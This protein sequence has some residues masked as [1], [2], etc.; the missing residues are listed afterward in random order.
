MVYRGL[1]LPVIHIAD[2]DSRVPVTF[3]GT[4]IFIVDFVSGLFIEAVDGLAVAVQYADGDGFGQAFYLKV[5]GIS[6]AVV[7]ASDIAFVLGVVVFRTVQRLVVDHQ[8][9]AASLRNQFFCNQDIQR[10]R[11]VIRGA[12]LDI[13]TPLRDDRPD[14]KKNAANQSAPETLASKHTAPLR[15]ERAKTLSLAR[16]DVESK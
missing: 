7:F 6:H 1:S 9:N 14:E 12:I 16:G 15:S 11:T 8:L 5:D 13:R 3:V 4:G 2:D 10:S